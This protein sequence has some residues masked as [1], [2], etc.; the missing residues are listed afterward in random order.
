VLQDLSGWG[1]VMAVDARTQL[2]PSVLILE[3]RFEA[4]G[5][6]PAIALSGLVKE[7]PSWFPLQIELESAT[8]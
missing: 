8:S 4:E 6:L 2:Q 1:H 3:L 5:A 7:Q